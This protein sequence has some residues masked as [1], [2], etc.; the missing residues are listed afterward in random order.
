MTRCKGGNGSRKRSR[1]SSRNW[2]K[3]RTRNKGR[4]RNRTRSKNWSRS[5]AVHR[6]KRFTSFPSPD[7]MSL[8]KL[9]LGRNNSVMTSL[10][11]PS[12]SLAVTSRL[13]T[14]NLGAFFLRCIRS[15]E[16]ASRNSRGGIGEGPGA[17]VLEIQI[18][19]ILRK[20][21][22]QQWQECCTVHKHQ[23]EIPGL[24]SGA[25]ILGSRNLGS[26]KAVFLDRGKYCIPKGLTP[27][28]ISIYLT[29][30]RHY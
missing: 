18:T 30:K 17:S 9:P 7:G 12:E 28:D 26:T 21:Q 25:G 29:Q 5:G 6:K 8:T 4:N 20:Q 11:P 14:G 1:N 2:S 3:N 15:K 19:N 27:V 16:G 22:E 10:F 13:G 23:N 24:G